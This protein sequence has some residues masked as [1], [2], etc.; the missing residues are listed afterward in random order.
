[1]YDFNDHKTLTG[2]PGIPGSPIFP[3]NPFTPLSPAVPRSPC[4]TSYG[5]MV[6]VTTYIQYVHLNTA[7]ESQTKHYLTLAP[8]KPS[9]GAPLGPGTPWAP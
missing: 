3:L 7:P 8:G 1:M 5:K 9:P 2:C 6:T 4:H